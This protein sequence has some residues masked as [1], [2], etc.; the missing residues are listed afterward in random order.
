MEKFRIRL[1]ERKY[2]G[3]RVLMMMHNNLFRKKCVCVSGFVTPGGLAREVFGSVGYETET[4]HVL[5]N[6]DVV[7]VRE[8]SE[9][10]IGMGR[11]MRVVEH[12]GGHFVPTR[13]DWRGILSDS[14]VEN[15]T[16]G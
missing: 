16:G 11:N 3:L 12:L 4:V 8:R 7:V 10:L 6:A 13:L 2:N 9:G 15:A 5:G 14:G 1:C